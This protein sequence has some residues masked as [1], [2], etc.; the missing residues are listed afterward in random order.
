MPPE[1][2]SFR[3]VGYGRRGW[4]SRKSGPT[5]PLT[6]AQA[7]RL[8][9]DGDP[10]AAVLTGAPDG[11]GL[12]VASL[13]RNEN[14][15]TVA[16]FEHD[17]A[18]ANLTHFWDQPRPG[19]PYRL[20]QVDRRN[21]NGAHVDRAELAYE[22]LKLEDTPAKW[23]RWTDE[24]LVVLEEREVDVARFDLPAPELG[25]YDAFLDRT[26]SFRLWPGLPEMP[27]VGPEVPVA[28]P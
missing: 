1:P 9:D 2:T 14:G 22:Y 8:H 15:I 19:G 4:N 5:Q 12:P 28:S 11:V 21:G 16:F 17:P 6:E 3:L 24:A 25:S 20:T 18:K 10:Y 26:V 7:R 23:C 27:W 13:T